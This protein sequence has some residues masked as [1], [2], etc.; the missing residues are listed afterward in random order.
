LV[1]GAVYMIAEAKAGATTA[2]GM[3]FVLLFLR[4]SSVDRAVTAAAHFVQRPA[5]QSAFPQTLS[6]TARPVDASP[7]PQGIECARQA[8]R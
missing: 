6:A 5:Y 3:S 7:R 2:R 4:Q 1:K 8:P